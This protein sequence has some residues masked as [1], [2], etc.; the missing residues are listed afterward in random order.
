RG[1]P[2]PGMPEV[3]VA[4]SSRHDV[5]RSFDQAS[6][7]QRTVPVPAG[8]PFELGHDDAPTR[9]AKRVPQNEVAAAPLRAPAAAANNFASRFAPAEKMRA[10][11]ARI[12]SASAFA[13]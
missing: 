1:T 7:A 10:A 3:K 4:S 8:R 11:P 5:P 2:A 13:D 12:E 9:T 6:A